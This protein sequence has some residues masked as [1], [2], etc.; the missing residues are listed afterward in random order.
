MSL[1]RVTTECV[2]VCVCDLLRAKCCALMCKV[3]LFASLYHNKLS[4]NTKLTC[5]ACFLG[6]RL[7]ILFSGVCRMP[8]ITRPTGNQIQTNLRCFFFFLA[9][10]SLRIASPLL[11][12]RVSG[13]NGASCCIARNICMR[14]RAPP[15]AADVTAFNNVLRG[16]I[17][18]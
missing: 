5:F 8:S 18:F 14:I 10:V 11:L 4:F 9:S 2:F 3:C 1:S 13:T 12:S 16:P 7:Q 6:R 15:T 17:R